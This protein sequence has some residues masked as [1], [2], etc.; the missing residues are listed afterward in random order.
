MRRQYRTLRR[1][2]T[3][4][5]ISTAKE[6]NKSLDSESR[7]ITKTLMTLLTALE[8]NDTAK[9]RTLLETT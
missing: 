2:L 8:T 7:A 1:R 6:T 9:L 5:C 4:E 3:A